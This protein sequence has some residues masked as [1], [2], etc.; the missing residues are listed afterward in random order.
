MWGSKYQKTRRQN[1]T[2]NS[3]SV[4][5]LNVAVATLM[6]KQRSNVIVNTSRRAEHK[7]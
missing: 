4:V 1:I 5:L 3:L 2:I 6:Q 7:E